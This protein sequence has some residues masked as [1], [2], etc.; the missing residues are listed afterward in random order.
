M[1]A[2]TSVRYA[3]TRDVKAQRIHFTAEFPARE[4]AWTLQLPTWRPG[5]YELGN[6]AQYVL[7]VKGM[8]DGGEVVRLAKTG[9]HSWSVP[10]GVTKVEWLFHADILNAGSTCIEDDLYYVNP[11]N[12]F[13]YDLERQDL[14]ADL[15][16]TDGPQQ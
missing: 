5:R 4:G 3:L 1:S 11:V 14:P 8:Q 15:V 16:L 12:C 6:F 13:M 10:A 9:L 7:W 2:A